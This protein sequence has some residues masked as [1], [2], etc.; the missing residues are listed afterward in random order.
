MASVTAAGNTWNTTGGNTTVVATPAV[1]DLII[2]FAGTSGLA[3]GT[4]AVSDNQSPAGVYEQIDVD[5]TGFSTTGVLTVW[6]RTRPITAASS[7]TFTATQG[8]STGGGLSVLRIAGIRIQGIAA[9]RGSGGQSTGTLGT[10]P[11]PVLLKRTGTTFSGT[12]AAL[13]GNVVLGAVANG[14]NPAT[15]TA[16]SSPAYTEDMDLGYATPTTGMEVIHIN[17]GETASTI[18]WG[19][20]SATA[21]ASIAIEIETSVPIIDHVGYGDEVTLIGPTIRTRSSYW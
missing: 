21:F 20:T 9:I 7:T 5:R 15:M 8:S 6:V 14:T 10:T 12:Q 4:T 19:G 17:S 16:R 18:T 3:G 11:A 1:G 13:T 2:I